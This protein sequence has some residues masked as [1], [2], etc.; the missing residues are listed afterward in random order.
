[1]VLFSAYGLLMLYPLQILDLFP[2]NYIQNTASPIVF[3]ASSK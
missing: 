1:M 2:Q 3:E